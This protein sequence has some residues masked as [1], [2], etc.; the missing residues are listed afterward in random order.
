MAEDDPLKVRLFGYGVP[1]RVELSADGAVAPMETDAAQEA[2][3]VYR[4]L[5]LL[6]GLAGSPRSGEVSAQWAYSMPFGRCGVDALPREHLIVHFCAEAYLDVLA[7]AGLETR[8]L[9][10]GEIVHIEPGTVIRLR[11]LPL[12]G[13]RVLVAFQ[14]EDRTPLSGNAGPFTLDGEVPEDWRERLVKCHAAFDEAAEQ[15]KKGWHRPLLQRFLETMADTVANDPEIEKIQD[16][17]RAAGSYDVVEEQVLFDR[18]RS[19]INEAALERIKA[20]DEAVFRFP[21]MFGGVAPLFN[22]I[23]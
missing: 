5:R 11:A 12:A 22:L 15:A 21:G 4:S 13:H 23:N 17:A 19:L 10:E 16:T 7:D 3:A 18:Q 1:Y 14:T 9:A 2:D 20:Q 6:K 8:Q